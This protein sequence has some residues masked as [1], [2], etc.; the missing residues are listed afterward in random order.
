M[1]RTGFLFLTFLALANAATSR[2][3]EPPQEIAIGKWSKPVADTRGYALRGRLV[4]AERRYNDDRREVAVYVELQDAS[5]ARGGGMRI[6]CDLGKSDLSGATKTGLTCELRDKNDQPVPS[7]PFPFSGGIPQSE[8]LYLPSDGAV[9]L[10]ASP[11]GIHRPGAMAI[12]PHPGQLWVIANDDPGEYSLTGTFIV[13]PDEGRDTIQDPQVW[14]G[15]IELPALRV[16]GRKFSAVASEQ[17]KRDVKKVIAP[18]ASLTA[19]PQAVISLKDPTTGM[20]FY[21]ESNGR[22]LVAF[23]TDG[24]LAWSV[25]LLAEAKI[26]PAH[27][28]PVIRHLRMQEVELRV[29]C[30]KSDEVKVETS[31]GKAEY[32]GAD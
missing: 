12:S 21:V 7:T 8:W 2:A 27:G 23:S 25:D 14:R 9:R 6:F 30:G 28:A 31:T 10:R 4:L 24:T 15:T 17:E 26:K 32:V 13:D 11:F 5:D 16:V 22:R 29:T 20:V 1:N 19:Y 18:H 3:S